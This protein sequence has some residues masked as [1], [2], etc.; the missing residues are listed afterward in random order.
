MKLFDLR[1]RGSGFTLGTIVSYEEHMHLRTLI[2]YLQC[3]ADEESEM[4]TSFLAQ[5]KQ[6]SDEWR[7]SYSVEDAKEIG[8]WLVKNEYCTE[9]D[10]TYTFTEKAMQIFEKTVQIQKELSDKG[11]YYCPCAIW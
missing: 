10:G 7:T 4:P 9:E 6:T 2:D 3:N 5:E 11:F 8:Q 1:L